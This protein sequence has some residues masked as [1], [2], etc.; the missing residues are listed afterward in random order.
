M[1]TNLRIETKTP[2][3]LLCGLLFLQPQLAFAQAPVASGATNTT[4]TSAG[5]GVP[6][7]N[8]AAPS[9]SG[10]SHNTY[11]SYNVG[12]QGLVLN[13]GDKS[14]AFRQSQLAGQIAANPNL[15]AGNQASIILNEVTSPNRSTLAGFTEVLGGRASVIV[16]NPFGI[17]CN[18]CGFIN[19]DRVSLVTG[20]PN[21]AGG[22]LGGF[23]VRGGDIFIGGTGINA[24]AQQMLDLVSRKITVNGQVNTSTLNIV[25]GA[26]NWN[27][28]S[29]ATTPIASDGSPAPAW[30][31]DSSALGGMYAGRI[32]LKSTE[33]GAGVRMLGNAAAT[34]DDFTITSAGKI[35]IRSQVSAARD[36]ALTSTV[37]LSADFSISLPQADLI[38][39]TDANLTAG[40]N[41]TL[42]GEGGGATITGGGIVATGALT[43]N[44]YSLTDT[45]SAT[46][47][48]ADANKRYG[49]TVALNGTGSWIRTDFYAPGSWLIDG[50]SYGAGS[51]L[52]SAVYSLSVGSSSPVSL[53]SGGTLSIGGGEVFLT[54]ASLQ[55]TG[56]MSVVLD[57]RGGSSGN[58]SI[59]SASKLKSTSGNIALNAT[60]A[61]FGN[62]GEISA[63]SG[64][65][66]IRGDTVASSGTL[67]AS[68][69]L[70]LADTRPFVFGDSVTVSLS[71]TTLANSVSI[72][73]SNRM[74]LDGSLEAAGDLNLNIGGNLVVGAS[75]RI[76]A[77]T[78]GS[79]TG[80]ITV[81]TPVN[82]AELMN[83]GVVHS[84]RNMAI[85]GSIVNY[86]SGGISA[87]GTMTLA[88]TGSQHMYN[89]GGTIYATEALTALYTD[90]IING[91]GGALETA[92]DMALTAGVFGNLADSPG[93]SITKAAGNLTVTAGQFTNQEQI[94]AGPTS[95]LTIQGFNTGENTGAGALLSAGTITLTGNGGGATFTNSGTIRADTLNAV[96]FGLTNSGSPGAATTTP[97]AATATTY[98]GLVLTLPTNPN[99]MFVTSLNPN[100]AYLVESNP[101]FTNLDNFL[102]SD[103]LAQKYDFKPDTIIK[104]LG[105]AAYET[106]LVQQ[107][108]IAQLGASML[109]GYASEKDQMR[110][111]MDHAGSHA[112]SLGLSYGKPLNAAQQANLKEDM[113]W[114]V[115]TTVNGQK[116]LAPVVYLA[117]STRE[118]FETGGGLIAA[119]K[120]NMNLTSLTNKEGG[121]ISGKS[122]DITTQ[123]DIRNTGGTI[124]GGDVALTSTGGSIINETETRELVSGKDFTEH[125]T[126]LG[127]QGTIS[128]TGNL[129]VD[130]AKDIVNKGARMGAEGDVS[131]S[132]GRDVVFDTVEKR[133]G[134]SAET[135]ESSIVSSKSTR[136]S[137]Y[138]VEQ[139]KSELSSG[140]NL[141]V[142]AKRDI[143]LAGTDAS[144][145]GSV[146]LDAGGDV[147]IVARE[148]KTE[149]ITT[150]EKSGLFVGGGLYGTEKVQTDHE[151][152][153]NVGSTITAGKDVSLAAGKTVKIQGSGVDAKGNIDIA[154]E[155]VKILAGKDVDRTTTKKETTAIFSI[156]G[157]GEVTTSAEANA[158]AS[159][160][161]NASL[162]NVG[163]AKAGA[164]AGANASS[165]DGSK[166]D[167]TANAGTGIT[168]KTGVSADASAGADAGAKASGDLGG[169]DLVKQTWSTTTDESTKAVGSRLGAGK[170][171]TITARKTATLQGAQVDAKGDVA[172]SAKDVN[173]LAAEDKHTVSETIRVDRAGLY[174]STDNTAKANTGILGAAAAGAGGVKGGAGADVSVS[175]E[176]SNAIDLIRIKKTQTDTTDTTNVGSSLTSGGNLRINSG[177]KLTVQ[178]SDIS[179]EQGVDIKARDME[180]VAGKDSHTS[181]TTTTEIRAGFYADANVKA[182]AEAGAK[183]NDGPLGAA[184]GANAGA[185]VSGEYSIGYQGKNTITKDTEST[186]TARVSTITSGSGSITRSAENSIKDVGTSID[187]A[188]DFSQT[189]KT[190]TSKA[191]A[192]TS[193]KTSSSITNSAK[194]GLYSGASANAEAGVD[195]SVGLGL[196]AEP[197]AEAK[198]SVVG[199]VKAAYSGE[200]STTT[201]KSSTAVVSSIK[202]G[203]N[204]KSVTSDKTSL[205]GTLISGGKGVE[206]EAGSLDY[207]AAK[208]TTSR[209]STGGSVNV[210]AGVGVGLSATTALAVDAN[211]AG[212]VKGS[213][214]SESTSK[215]VA[216]GIVSGGDISIK[217]KGDTRLEGTSLAS[218]GDTTVDAGGKLVFD[219]ARDTTQKSET[220]VEAGASLTTSKGNNSIGV[221]AE[222][223]AGYTQSSSETSDAK[224]GSV[225]TGGNL[226]LSAGKSASFEGTTIDA[227][228]DATIRGKDGVTMSAARS[229]SSS[230]EFGV[231]AS[232]KV[233][234]DKGTE[235]GKTT[236]SGAVEGSLG[237]SGSSTKQS[238][239]A[240]GSVTSGGN[241]KIVSDKDVTLEGTA[242]EAGNKASI[243]AGGSVNLKAAESNSESASFGVNLSGKAEAKT[244]T[245]APTP[246]APSGGAG[247]ATP[248]TATPKPDPAK[249]S[250]GTGGTQGSDGGKKGNAD[251]AKWQDKQTEVLT[252]LKDKKT[253]ESKGK[254]T[255]TGSGGT[256]SGGTGSGTTSPTGKPGST[257]ETGKTG[258]V[259]IDIQSGKSSAKKG[260]SIKAGAGGVEITAGGGDVNMEGTKLSTTGDANISAK[261]D[262]R[263]TAAKSTESSFGLSVDATAKQTTKTPSYSGEKIKTP[264]DPSAKSQGSSADKP[265][266]DVGGKTTAQT[267][268]QKKIEADKKSPKKNSESLAGK[269][270][271]ADKKSPEKNTE[272]LTGKK[273]T[274]A[275]TTT[276]KDGEKPAGNGSPLDNQAGAAGSVAINVGS[277]VTGS[278]KADI[279][280][281][282]KLNITSGGKTSLTDTKVKADG[283]ENIR[284]GAGTDRKAQ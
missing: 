165:S 115:E 238:D 142:K 41:L 12:G 206:L 53:Y 209:T 173:I 108:L 224:A 137:T 201:E 61:D 100:S 220:A 162:Q 204:V 240:A 255:D 252:E 256:S 130:A 68:G 126:V 281:G 134:S 120:V 114:M 277:A 121:T 66:T 98:P 35:E 77:A 106:Y 16:A 154:G 9:A 125:R 260:G 241:L 213:G 150:S 5:A 237:V 279:N 70:D 111:L 54:N 171:I 128:A 232:L 147:N 219:A 164:G 129:S 235:D 176:S 168:S 105:D 231:G 278:E 58:I 28:A 267:P 23:D 205:E 118:M 269:K 263:I 47:G 236:K 62:Q 52:A 82:G 248:P 7:V 157:P 163:T 34:A 158:G 276:S 177:N 191:A 95:T 244:E 152:T 187:A 50:V 161:A 259:G 73:A 85:T 282:G 184:A 228:G 203:G 132:A 251:V 254:T 151:Q 4:V 234:A 71:G 250:P 221:G 30:V 194:L 265:T 216:G 195:A 94:I 67:H 196:T 104:R 49:S 36:L 264:A 207:S 21:I 153:R 102:G 247:G 78:S 275:K 56:D 208:D 179:G 76:L 10:L 45:A 93:G 124:K 1:K 268:A 211:L 198:A 230:T 261:G 8:I 87:L 112:R 84:F 48:I 149:T 258:T 89:A 167:S 51:S 193:E 212:E 185:A 143:T 123:G 172:L 122:L 55:S 119:D 249:K 138:N 69:T 57:P 3:M 24:S 127:K 136:T 169:L 140:G 271:K 79:G 182:S 242:I 116:V 218:K 190:F 110:G 222:V 19:T 60:G 97:L 44:L 214:S 174:L 65:L 133:S 180:F 178:G 14:Q 20:T 18:G 38:A 11:T 113:I 192:D 270:T 156:T 83:Y 189:A 233:S 262:V 272:S 80:S 15:A 199:G 257:K 88:G 131:L 109:K 197:N 243:V 148:N 25:A 91:A 284:A 43:Y 145:K 225:T 202:A 274:V 155:D 17:T 117:A 103:Y 59:G 227:G 245:T 63:D 40:R 186:T 107:Q 246:G 42:T 26:N 181:S 32:V 226:K 74:N 99:G 31:I 239:A 166:S 200:M 229:T 141:T 283:G 160:D 217:T 280:T 215:A 159:A 39:L 13:N 64:N 75:G 6:V 101:L 27:Y 72:T 223:S 144:A 146:G 266:A 33:D 273:T 86:Y 96:G 175:A 22:V 92:G 183:G 253:G 170:N 135:S 29:G 81:G 37:P 210:S 2:A 139:V 188:G 46:P 90:A